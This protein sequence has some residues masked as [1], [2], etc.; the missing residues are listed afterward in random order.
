MNN[1]ENRFVVI[2]DTIFSVFSMRTNSFHTRKW[3]LEVH[4]RFFKKETNLKICHF[5]VRVI[6]Y[7]KWNTNTCLFTP[8]F[9]PFNKFNFSHLWISYMFRVFPLKNHA[10]IFSAWLSKSYSYVQILLSLKV[11]PQMIGILIWSVITAPFSRLTLRSKNITLFPW[12]KGKFTD[13]QKFIKFLHKLFQLYFSMSPNKKDI[14]CMFLSCHVRES[15]CSRNR[16]IY[17]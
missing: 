5:K 16:L 14:D 7:N 8:N 15:R 10:F 17:I 6:C 12:P 3:W 1:A 4:N 9:W 13:R 2:E 11:W